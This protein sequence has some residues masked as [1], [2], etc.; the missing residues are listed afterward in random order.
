MNRVFVFQRWIEGPGEP[1]KTDKSDFQLVNLRGFPIMVPGTHF[2]LGFLY[3][4][5][6]AEFKRLSAGTSGGM[7]D[8]IWAEID[9]GG[10]KVLAPYVPENSGYVSRHNIR[11]LREINADAWLD[12]TDVLHT[13]GGFQ[14][15]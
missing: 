3:D 11:L 9:V 1:A 8:G 10:D 14:D 12:E 15:D 5:S 13:L 4:V 2:V 6:R 7:Y